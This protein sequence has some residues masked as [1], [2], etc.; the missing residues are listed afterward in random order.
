MKVKNFIFD[1]HRDT[2]K[3]CQLRKK[4]LVE[5]NPKNNINKIKYKNNND[6]EMIQKLKN[7]SIS[8]DQEKE[9]IGYFKDILNQSKQKNINEYNK[10]ISYTS[11]SKSS[12]N[13]DNSTSNNTY[14]D[15][16][17][18]PNVFYLNEKENLHKKTHVSYL[19][20][21]LRANNNFK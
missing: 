19:F 17:Y 15:Q 9:Y 16:F 14:R 12:N 11:R 2:K 5:I 4:V 8:L 1:N 18:Y 3:H 20:S 6:L 10:L 21:K 13:Y 7:K